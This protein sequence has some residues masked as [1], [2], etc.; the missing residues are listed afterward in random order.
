MARIAN[1]NRPKNTRRTLMQMLSYLGRH[2]WYMLMIAL[3]VTV[4]ASASILGTYLLKPVINNYI[5]PGDIPGLVKMLILMGILYLCGALSCYVYNQMMVHISQQV[6]SEI[7]SD[8]FVH[9]QRLP[10]TYFDAHTHGELMSRFTNDVDTISEALNSS[11][12]M[13]IQS[14]ITITGTLAMLLILS[15]KLSLIVMVFLALM[16]LF[17]RF[18]GRRSKKYFVQQQKYLGSINGFVEEMVAGQKVEKVFNHE[19]Q[20]YEEFCRR[21]EAFRAAATKA[22]TY[23]GMTVPTI[24]SLSYIN[25][26][27]SACVGGLFALAGLTDLGTLASYLVYVRQSAMPMN[28]FTQQINF[29]LAALSGAERIFDMMNEGQESDEGSVTL[30]NVAVDGNGEMKECAGF[31]Q[32]F[33]WKVPAGVTVFTDADNSGQAFRLVPLKGDVRFNQ[34]VFGYTPEKTI[35]NGI[36]LYAKPGQKIAFVGSTGAG[37]TTIINLVNRFYEINSG[38]ITYDG[39]DIRDIKKDDLRRSLSMVIQDTHLFTGTIADNIRYG[40]LDATDG[41][42][43]NAAKVA[44][45][46]SFIRRLPQGYDTVLHSD[47]SNL[48]QGQRQ[49]LA[50]ARAAISRPPVLILDEA[51]SSID[52]RTEKLIEKGM[53]ALMDGRTVFVIAHRLSTV[54]NSKAIMVLEK[55]EIIERGNHDELLEQKGR[56]YQLYTG[57]FELE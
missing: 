37:K 49:L 22:L 57:Q 52:T 23:S 17:I 11:F 46:H 56:Y 43:V 28:Q 55:G 27:L 40:R 5:I 10:L 15:L 36:S 51:T 45:A 18:N 34:V 6:V 44:N 53:D 42:V 25:Y 2:K 38:S 4:S 20:D 54:R 31:T 41:D 32:D 12:A 33:A 26:A 39:I 24:V 14:F 1:Y 48:S 21:N 7:R 19:A 50:I 29:L 30:C 16:I 13:M 8:L 3:L 9:T 47:G 35:L